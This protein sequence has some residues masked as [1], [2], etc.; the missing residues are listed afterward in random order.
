MSTTDAPARLPRQAVRFRRIP[1]AAFMAISFGALV[2][3]SVGGVLALSVTANYRNTFDL[4]GARAS[5]LVDAME[6]SLRA[7][8]NRAESAVDGI[9]ELYADGRFEIDDAEAMSTVLTGALSAVPEASA[10]IIY[11]PDM[12]YRGVS[13]S[14]RAHG[15]G[16]AIGPIE[17][18][19]VTDPSILAALERRRQMNGRQWGA[20]VNNSYGL[21]ANV[22]TPLVRDGVVHGW[23]VAPVELQTLSRITLDL[24]TRF[25]T[26]AFILDG[27]N[28]VLADQRLVGRA[29]ESEGLLPLTPLGRFG[30]PVLARYT[31]RKTLSELEAATQRGVEVSEI[32]ESDGIWRNLPWN[33]DRIYIMITRSVRGFGDQPWTI[34][35]YYQRRDIG[36]E[37]AR[38]WLSALVGAGA[39]VCALFAA[40]LLGKRLSQPVRTIAGHAQRVAAFDLD[41]LTPLPRSRVTEIDDQAT[42]FNAMLVGLRAF[43][44]YIPRALVAKLVRAGE[45]GAAEPREAILTV[46]FT[47]IAGFTT[48]SEQLGASA[49]ARLLN[50]H[51]ALLCHE[52]DDH[53][54]TVDK[55]V[56]DG[57]MAF[58]GAPDRL[59]GHAAAA[60]RAAAGIRA[61]M[62]EDNGLADAEG[63]PRL[64]VRIGIHTGPV[65]VGNIGAADRVNY[66]IVGDTVNVSQRLQELG[67][68]VAADAETA[69]VMSGE[70]ASR[71]DERFELRSAGQHRL[72]GRGEATEV[73]TLGAIA[74][75]MPESQSLGAA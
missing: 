37:L 44:T 28:R 2:F 57:M 16:M 64:R 48:L 72:R 1:V 17:P 36:E 53:G 75:H 27:D 62:A 18:A 20:F 23:I 61:A 38:A 71:L 40:I 43:S 4:L 14:A 74:E 69:I 7:H 35:A 5:L 15:P 33:G 30:D 41:A 45:V 50:H 29:A 21:F 47:D 9:E 65:I 46:M 55:F 32:A 6:D 34:G 54:G 49:A 12:R 63:R 67:K 42:A 24:S 3:L 66:T 52:V 73:F 10:M 8:M 70:T 58:F 11:T 59:K 22:S 13:R 68:L 26:H 25:G 39:L 60:V 31:Q 51:L 56:G 19:A